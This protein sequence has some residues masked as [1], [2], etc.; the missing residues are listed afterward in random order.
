MAS[1]RQSNVPTVQVF[2]ER[3]KVVVGSVLGIGLGTNYHPLRKEQAGSSI[4]ILC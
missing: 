1:S 4:Y 2:L 3:I